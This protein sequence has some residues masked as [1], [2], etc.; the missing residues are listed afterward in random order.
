MAFQDQKKPKN[1]FLEIPRY[2]MESSLY[3][4]VLLKDTEVDSGASYPR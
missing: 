3:N 1:P 4:K 2:D